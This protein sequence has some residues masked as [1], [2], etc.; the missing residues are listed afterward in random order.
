MA[1]NKV[2]GT[3]DLIK[4]FNWDG[5]NPRYAE[6]SASLYQDGYSAG[7]LDLPLATNV[8]FIYKEFGEKINHVLQN[9]VTKWISTKAY[10]IGD[11]VNHSGRIYQTLVAN[12]N[13]E[14]T[15]INTNWTYLGNKA[16]L[17][18]I[19]DSV[20]TA[21]SNIATNTSNIS[22]LDIV[23]NPT[24]TG[25]ALKYVRVN[26]GATAYEVVALDLGLPAG[27]LSSP[28]PTYD[29]AQPKRVNFN[30]DL[31]ARSKD[32]TANIIL[33]SASRNLDLATN[34]A[35]GLVDGLT[36]ANNTWYYV[37]AYSGGYVASTTNGASTLTIGTVAQKV[38]QLP[39]T[40]RT[41]GSAKDTG[42]RS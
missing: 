37:Y 32:N 14:P 22:A 26:A 20:T 35:N 15:T 40:L 5:T 42:T 30:G 16:D 13:S 12:T 4:T 7:L 9:G 2:V 34:G 8:N 39:L 11:V 19:I 10:L 3:P 24:V 27:Y 28:V 33:S 1:S 18:T 25:N 41:D 38:V 6:P 17:Q 31:T 29:S 21:N 23:K 36:V